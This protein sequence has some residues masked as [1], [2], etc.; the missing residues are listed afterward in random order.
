MRE[1]DAGVTVLLRGEFDL[2]SLRDL[3]DA[4]SS[5]AGLQRRIVL[6]LTGVT[7]LDLPSAREIA[8][9][10]GLYAHRL[11][12]RNL[13]PQARASIRAFGLADWFGPPPDGGHREPVLSEA[14]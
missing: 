12:P 10:S 3:R 6:D 4:L 2:F 8:V 9:R 1:S 14:S 13:S 7:F 5:V 11:T